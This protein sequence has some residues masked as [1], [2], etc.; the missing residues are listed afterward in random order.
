MTNVTLL[1]KG[2]PNFKHTNAT[3]R[4]LTVLKN[5]NLAYFCFLVRVQYSI[6]E[7]PD[8]IFKQETEEN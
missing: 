1:F 4:S 6:L 2:I 5:T 7:I 3:F 8:T